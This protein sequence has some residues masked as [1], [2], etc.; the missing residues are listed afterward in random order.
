VAR[1]SRASELPSRSFRSMGT[2]VSITLGAD[3]AECMESVTEHIREIFDRLESEMSVYRADSEISRLSRMAG[4]A[5]V[6]VS[7]DTYKVLELAQYFGTLSAGAFDSTAGPLMRLWG[8]NGSSLPPVRPSQ[9]AIHEVLKMVDGRRLVLRDGTAFLPVKGM[10]EDLGGIAK[11]YAVDRAYD[12]CLSVG[13]RSFLIDFSGNMR[14]AGRPASGETWQ[15]GVRNP[16]DRARLIGKLI[17]PSGGALATSG[18]YERFVDIGGV[19]FSHI[20]DPRTGCPVKGTASVTVL[21]ADAATA[22]ALSTSCYVLG[23]SGA[24]ECL[25]KV[26]SAEL[27]IVPDQVSM[28][29]FLTRGFNKLFAP[30]PELRNSVKLLSPN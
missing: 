29:F 12:Y 23:P 28:E 25:K 19:R 8:F 27:L 30:A 6:V 11:G 4:V 5:P 16:F 17:L 14:A 26:A 20:I 21:C 7:K 24:R 2:V 15:I 9:E 10:T 18:G 1:L 13:I 22:D 3:Y